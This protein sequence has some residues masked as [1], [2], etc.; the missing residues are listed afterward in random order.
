MPNT[1]EFLAGSL[2]LEQLPYHWTI[3]N[4]IQRSFADCDGYV[5][6]KLTTLGRSSDDEIPS[7]LIVTRQ[8]GIL[9]VDVIEEHVDGAVEIDGAVAWNLSNGKAFSSRTWA[10]ELYVDDLVSRLKNDLTLYDRTTRTVSVPIRSGI[11]FCQ[12]DDAEIAAWG[13]FI[14]GQ[15]LDPILIKDFS[16]WIDR[17]EASY[18]CDSDTLDR[19][20]ALLEGTFVYGAKPSYAVSTPLTTMNDYIQSSLKTIFKQDDAQRVASMQL[21]PGPQRIRGLAG[22]GKTV[23]LS[24]KAAITHKRFPDFK[25]LYLFNTQSLYS[26][27]TSL[28][29]RYY[30]I[31]AKKAPDFEDCLNVLH[32]WGGKQKAGLYSTLCQQFGVTPLTW[33]EVRGA[34]DPLAYIFKRLLDQVGEKLQPIYDLVLIDEAQDLPPEVFETVFRVTKGAA[35][36]KRIIWAYDEFQS[37]RDVEMKGPSELFGKDA[38]GL[39]NLPDEL[40]HGEYDGGIRKDFVLPN[41]YRT[42]RSVLMVAHGVAL[43]LYA[44]KKSTMLYLPTDWTALG[45]EVVT[46]KTLTIEP[47]DK[48]V[49]KRPDENSKNRLEGLLIDNDRS[50]RELVQIARHNSEL[51]QHNAIAKKIAEIIQNE[52]VAPEEIIVVNL[53][54]AKEKMLALQRALTAQ[55]VPSVLPGFFES[56]DVFKPKG[57]VTI[58]T[59]FRAK[60]NEANIVFV[61]NSQSIASDFT[62][63]K[64]NAFFVAVT[65]SRGWCFIN[66]IGAE[67]DAL[68]LEL[69]MIQDD[70][71]EFKF[72]CPRQED[73]PSRRLLTMSDNELNKMQEIVELLKKNPDLAKMVNESLQLPK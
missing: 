13:Q 39:P 62:L 6:Y 18:N 19:I 31:E 34:S 3:V 15:N 65:R 72:V 59:T 32:A 54:S 58:S 21:P 33:T 20:L 17:A 12:N 25:I 46:P 55:N 23:V 35:D 45:Y 56:A 63:R 64:R 61:V 44:P 49:L 1:F 37:L 52:G 40:L 14:D 4:E 69:N 71:P 26:Q 22:T 7:F 68:I 73:L 8:H 47:G 10:L 28:I 5:A 9:L 48:V 29:T 27:I 67:M 53:Y 2:A 57:F 16:A 60:G 38:T 50:P 36:K 11:V 43:G 41:C 70:F 42:P 66:G 24:L 30:S 51:D